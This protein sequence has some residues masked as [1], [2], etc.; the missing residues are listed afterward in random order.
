M[1]VPSRKNPTAGKEVPWMCPSGVLDG[2][3][4][5]VC[6]RMRTC[7]HMCVCVCLCASVRVKGACKSPCDEAVTH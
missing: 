2:V 7:V 1:H 4:A 6:V 5:C 3:R